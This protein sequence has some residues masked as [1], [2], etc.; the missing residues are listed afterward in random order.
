MEVILED[1]RGTLQGPL[2]EQPITPFGAIFGTGEQKRSALSLARHHPFENF[3]GGLG[4]ERSVE[5]GHVDRFND[6]AGVNT[7]K[8]SEFM[9]ETEQQAAVVLA[10][11]ITPTDVAMEFDDAYLVAGSDNKL[12]RYASDAFTAVSTLPGPATDIIIFEQATSTKGQYAIVAYSDGT[13]SNTGMRYSTDGTTWTNVTDDATFL[14]VFDNKLIVYDDIGQQIRSTASITSPA[15]TNVVVNTQGTARGMTIFRDQDGQPSIWYSTEL[16][17]FQI[18]YTNSRSHFV[19]DYSS[20]P[21]DNNGKHLIEYNGQLFFPMGQELRSISPQG[22][23]ISTGPDR[24]DGVTNP[25]HGNR[26]TNII[27]LQ[28]FLVI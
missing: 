19:Y 28:H 25:D 20:T 9:L 21:Y 6:Q 18:D 8:G 13:T 16:G 1:Q 5:Q 10:A 26:I 23:V 14:A 3:G 24:D 12:Y 15:W 22:S 27:T 4:V 2:L 7:L 11:G 17:L